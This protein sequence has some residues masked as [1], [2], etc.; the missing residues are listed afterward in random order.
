MDGHPPAEVIVRARAGLLTQDQAAPILE[1]YQSCDTCFVSVMKYV[2]QHYQ[3]AKE[4]L[5]FGYQEDVKR[6]K[7]RPSEIPQSL[8]ERIAG[9]VPPLM[10]EVAEL[11]GT[12]EG[13]DLLSED[14][15]RGLEHVEEALAGYA[16]RDY[17][18]VWP[19][20]T[21][22]LK[23]YAQ[24]LQDFKAGY[25]NLPVVAARILDERKTGPVWSWRTITASLPEE[26]SVMK[27]LKQ[28]EQCFLDLEKAGILIRIITQRFQAAA[29]GANT[30]LEP[31]IELPRYVKPM[32]DICATILSKCSDLKYTQRIRDKLTESFKALG[33]Q[34]EFVIVRGQE[35]GFMAPK[36]G[37]WSLLSHVDD[38][39]SVLLPEIL[40]EVNENDGTVRLM[41]EVKQYV[42]PADVELTDWILRQ[43]S[44]AERAILISRVPLVRIR[45]YLEEHPNDRILVVEWDEALDKFTD[46]CPGDSFV[47]ILGT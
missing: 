41:A 37:F 32:L 26:L 10:N 43:G 17:P 20:F 46:F 9:M 22:A 44:I 33:F 42:N 47:S 1:H 36:T 28:Q 30:T 21:D 16:M 18:Q 11:R 6:A 23:G 3:E 19:L 38:F 39:R 29:R 35:L 12:L 45:P 34:C 13:L 8:R 15:R 14:Q 4:Y 2:D 31:K 24:T 25:Q 5:A 7:E 40:G 27:S